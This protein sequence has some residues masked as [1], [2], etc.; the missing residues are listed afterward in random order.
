MMTE[1]G[2]SLHERFVHSNDGDR[3]RT[4]QRH[5]KEWGFVKGSH[6][7]LL[8]NSISWQSQDLADLITQKFWESKTDAQIWKELE[9]QG[10]TNIS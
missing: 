2:M 1:F 9:N 5:L 8:P 3:V 7:E 10:Y 6:F 4:L